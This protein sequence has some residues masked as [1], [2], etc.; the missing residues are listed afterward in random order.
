MEQSRKKFGI[1][2]EN[3]EQI[4]VENGSSYQVNR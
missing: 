2:L 4:K 3:I 1:P